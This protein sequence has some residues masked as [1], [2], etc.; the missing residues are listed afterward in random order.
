MLHST[1]QS[2]SFQIPQHGG[3]SR[4]LKT[5]NCKCTCTPVSCQSSRP[6]LTLGPNGLPTRAQKWAIDEYSDKENQSPGPSSLPPKKQK[7]TYTKRR[8]IDE[9]LGD[10][11]TVIDKAGWS[12][13]N[14]LC[15]AFRHK[16]DNGKGIHHEQ[17]HTNSIQGFLSGYIDRTPT[18]ILDIWFH[19]LDSCFYEDTVLMCFVTPPN[20]DIKPVWACL[21]PF[22]V[23][24]ME[25]CLIREAT[26]ATCPSSGL[27]AVVSCKSSLNK[28]EWVDVGVTSVPEV[29]EIPKTHQPLTWHYFT[30]ITAQEPCICH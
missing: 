3:T 23:Q 6:S 15:Y 13:V 24:I 21:T 12:F 18:D 11:F 28:A 9:K 22:A 20:R 30:K 4:P 10:I 8:T 5:R 25:Q 19:S 1:F 27:H 16:D 2:S 29:S 7:R 14:F 17:A 26:N